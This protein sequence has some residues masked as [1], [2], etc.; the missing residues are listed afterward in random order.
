MFQP[1]PKE[2]ARLYK[3]IVMELLQERPRTYERLRRQRSLLETLNQYAKELKSSHAESK[4]ELAQAH[5]G[6]DPGLISSQAMELAIND[7]VDRLPSESPP[8]D[9]TLSLDEAIAHVRRPSPRG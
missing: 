9:E 3:T 1:K 2:T 7:L 6:S 5:P 8:S 4:A